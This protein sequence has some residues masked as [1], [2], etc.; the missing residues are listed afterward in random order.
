MAEQAVPTE[1]SLALTYITRMV[2]GPPEMVTQTVTALQFETQTVTVVYHGGE[3]T[4]SSAILN[5]EK[6]IEEDSVF[7]PQGGSPLG[8]AVSL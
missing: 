3:R 7:L 2:T 8:A 4:P 6:E 5:D 1:T